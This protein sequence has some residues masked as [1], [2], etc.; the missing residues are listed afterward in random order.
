MLF[1][2]LILPNL[3][4]HKLSLYA[5]VSK[6]VWDFDKPDNVAGIIDDPSQ[7]QLG[8][9]D[10]GSDGAR[11]DTANKLWEMLEGKH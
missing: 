2:H 10:L 6:I 5:H 7:A 4:S 3:H 11:Y 1:S 8:P 9:F